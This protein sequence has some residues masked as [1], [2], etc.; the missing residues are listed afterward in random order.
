MERDQYAVSADIKEAYHHIPVS[1]DLRQ[2]LSFTYAGRFF[3]YRGMPFGVKHAPRV[4]TR[5][6]HAAMVEIRKRWEIQSVQYLD[7][8]LFLSV[9]PED[10]QRKIREIVQFLEC[11]GW[12]INREKSNFVPS[13]QFVF[14]GLLWDTQRM[15][16]KIEEK[17]RIVL[18]KHTKQW[19]RWVRHGKHVPVRHLARLIGQLS[20][21]RIQHLCASLYLSKLNKMKSA[22]VIARG[23]NAT[24]Q[25][26]RSILGE[27]LWW[28]RR[29][30][31][32]KTAPIR[33][34]GP[35]AIV[36]T[37][38][39]PR[40]WGGWMEKEEQQWYVEGTWQKESLHTSN[41]LEMMAVFLSLKHFYSIGKL[42]G[43]RIIQL[44]TDNTTVMYDVNK[45]RGAATLLHPLKMI[46]R[47]L[48]LHQMQMTT[49][50]IPGVDN[51]IADSLSRLAR[52]GDYSL[53]QGVYEKGIQDLRVR[54]QI[55][56]FANSANRKCVRYMTLGQD[57]GAVGR[58]A[59]SLDW[60]GYF[61][62]IHPPIP[63]IPRCIRKVIQNG[64]KAIMVV[65]AWQ[66]Q[67]WSEL[68]R[69]ITLRQVDLG[70]ST[71]ILQPGPHMMRAGTQ[72]PPGT[73]LMCHVDGSIKMDGICGT[74]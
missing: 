59:F 51:G 55:D 40:G 44:R 18:L 56:L 22:A 52:S 9:D 41:Y 47:F 57:A 46:A 39:S 26:T 49:Q 14:L 13:Q 54:P 4:F 73:L 35:M 32:N 45:L 16:V 72:L 42:T 28:S 43:V 37:D 58:D 74:L 62:F 1:R 10:L 12:V 15:E 66:G 65:P 6:M 60:K 61:F 23:W 70:K 34:E 69:Q 25:L 48:D 38:A 11:L 19:I 5:I 7:D 31:E 53:S 29:L 24:V 68:L 64:T 2:Y 71:D 27:L 63:L 50:H 67:P 33:F 21:T 20:Q 3:Q 17:R 36:C 8:L 30:Q